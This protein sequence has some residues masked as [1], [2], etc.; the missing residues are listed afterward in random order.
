MADGELTLKLDDETVRRL[1]E[2][3]DAAGRSVVDYVQDLIREGLV[4]DD[5]AEDV[6]IAE[7]CDRSGVSH[8]VEEAMSHFRRELHAQAKKDR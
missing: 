7:E 2:A 1:Q 6:R 3:A 4:D 5:W 8:S